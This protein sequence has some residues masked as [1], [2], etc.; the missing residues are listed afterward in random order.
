MPRRHLPTH[1]IDCYLCHHVSIVSQSHLGC[2][3]CTCKARAGSGTLRVLVCL[4]F[5]SACITRAQEPNPLSSRDGR[6]LKPVPKQWKL[7]QSAL[8]QKLKEAM[9]MLHGMQVGLL[10]TAWGNSRQPGKAGL[11]LMR[12]FAY[13]QAGRHEQA[14]KVNIGNTKLLIT[15]PSCR[16]HPMHYIALLQIDQAAP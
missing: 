16:L 10:M 11:A 1:S 12:G 7:T 5:W 15:C 9:H 13:V 14:L 3:S 4:Q 8:T 6:Q 2:S